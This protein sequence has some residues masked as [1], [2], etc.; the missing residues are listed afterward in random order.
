MAAAPTRRA[1]APVLQS[2]LRAELAAARG[3]RGHATGTHLPPGPWSDA[4]R[5]TGRGPL[6]L[7]CDSLEALWLSSAACE[8]FD[9][10]DAGRH[11]ALAASE[12]FGEWL[13]IIEGA[14][15]DGLSTITFSTSGTTGKPKRCTHKLADLDAEAAH[16]AGLFGDRRRV[17]AFVPAHHVYGFL[18]TALLPDRLDAECLDTGPAT[19]ALAALRPG[20][21]IVAFPERWLWIERVVR[22][23][24]ADIRG[25]TSTAPC[26]RDL[27]E[28][29][30]KA[31]LDGL[32]EIYGSSETAGIGT[33]CWPETAYRLLPRWSFAAQD[34]RDVLVDPAG[35]SVAVPDALERIDADAFIPTSRLDGAVQ[36][37]G[38][39]VHPARIAAALR[40]RPGV[41]EAAVRLMRPDEGLRLKAFIVADGSIAQE[42]VRATLASWLAET[43]DPAA[44][45]VDFRF[46]A[47]LPRNA[48]GKLADW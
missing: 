46:G 11:H 20:D 22:C 25:V 1:L 32:T 21:L 15:R 45:P 39:N 6:D 3:K 5:I 12:R 31:G 18:F 10:A 7:G 29:L 34:G 40:G 43:M 36:V 19:E 16:F 42:A 37:G 17:L 8:M 47:R 4:A 48:L 41:A 30:I 9:L 33:R 38:T 28:A 14:W 44:R 26:P 23:F 35:G 24:G 27:V 13:D 2:L